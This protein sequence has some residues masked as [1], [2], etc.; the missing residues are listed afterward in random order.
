[1]EYA[2]VSAV[3]LASG[4]AERGLDGVFAYNDEYAALLLRVLEDAGVDVPDDVAVVGCDDLVTAALQRP[5][6]TT[7]RLDAPSAAQVAAALHDL[8]ETGTAAP[9]PA[10]E[11]VLVRRESA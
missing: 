1:M 10:V 7:I 6:L 2:P 9:L 8:I 4:W 11:P 3:E 5:A